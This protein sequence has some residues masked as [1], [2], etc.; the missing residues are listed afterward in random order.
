MS[1]HGPA[2]LTN[3]A[4]AE[5]LL[6]GLASGDEPRRLA[7]LFAPDADFEVPGD[8]GA[9]PWIGHRTGR[10]AAAAF[11]TGTRALLERISFEVDDILSS[12]ARAVVVGELASRVR[13]TEKVVETGFA[14]VLT[15]GGGLITRFQMF[16]D[17]FAVSRAACRP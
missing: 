14:I 17:S 8:D 2:H 3:R 12:D 15:I 1:A 9:L 16:E 5:R 4:I 6:A 13:A 10:E 11:V 7:E